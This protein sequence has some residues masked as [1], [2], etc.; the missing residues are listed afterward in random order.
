MVINLIWACNYGNDAKV[1][2]ETTW[3]LLEY[4]IKFFRLFYYSHF[5][6][7][8]RRKFL[9]WIFAQNHSFF[10]EIEKSFVLSTFTTF[11]FKNSNFYQQSFFPSIW[12][13]FYAR[14][15]ISS[16]KTLFWR[17]NQRYF[18]IFSSKECLFRQVLKLESPSETTVENCSLPSNEAVI[19]STSSSRLQQSDLSDQ[20]LC[21]LVLQTFHGKLQDLWQ[22]IALMSGMCN[23]VL[24]PIIYAF[25]YSQFRVRITQTWRQF[26]TQKCNRN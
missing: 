2:W 1:S 22:K 13:V 19:F 9:V 12:S 16:L 14:K 26:W 5:P 25:W 10:R 23:S 6:C 11:L 7:F 20:D 18:S 17:K 3:A 21:F 4:Q 24:N 8:F 15:K